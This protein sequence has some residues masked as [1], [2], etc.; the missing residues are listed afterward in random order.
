MKFRVEFGFGENFGKNVQVVG[1][2]QTIDGLDV[3]E[4]ESYEEAAKEA[5]NIDGL[6]N[7]IFKVCELTENEF[8]KLERNGNW[9]YYIF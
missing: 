6:E 5:V 4:A 3:I 1:E 7:A 9:V 2:W 8:G